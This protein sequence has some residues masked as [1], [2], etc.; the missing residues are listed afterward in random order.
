MHL[1]ASHLCS[2][3]K[4]GLNLVLLLYF[5]IT[6][7]FGGINILFSYLHSDN[8]PFSPKD[9]FYRQILTLNKAVEK[10]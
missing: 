1:N 10:S 5:V 7:R 9:S 6:F 4:P 2:S 8:I 3:N